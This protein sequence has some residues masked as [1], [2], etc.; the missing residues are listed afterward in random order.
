MKYPNKLARTAVAVAALIA[1]QS[2]PA[3]AQLGAQQ[4]LIEPNVSADSTMTRVPHITA[5][6]AAGLTAAR[7]ILGPSALDSLLAAKLS[8][9]QRT[10]VFGKMFVHADVNRGS[11]AD[12]MLIPG[13]DAKKLTAIKAGRPWKDFASFRAEFTKASSAAEAARVEQYLFIPVDLNTFTNDIMDTFA[14]IGVGTNR[15]KR[16]FAEYR[17]WTSYEQFDREIGKYVRSNPKEVGRL[18]RYVIITK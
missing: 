6:I 13:M 15:W 4:G 8:K 14:S 5:E 9:A 7:P 1:A 10:E 18:K 17:P 2:A 3:L 16:E 12:L 11:D